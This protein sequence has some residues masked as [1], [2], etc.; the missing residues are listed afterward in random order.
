M[1]TA[2]ALT[3]EDEG[4]HAPGPEEQ[5]SDSLYF[6]GGDGREGWGISEYLVQT[7]G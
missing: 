6:G 3:A 7:D 1:A 5:W 4:F 2:L